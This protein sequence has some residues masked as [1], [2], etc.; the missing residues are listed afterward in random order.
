[1]SNTMETLSADAIKHLALHSMLKLSTTNHGMNDLHH[2][3]L[4]VFL[5][6]EVLKFEKQNF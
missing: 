1:M 2:R 4:L 5:A 6:Q 3:S